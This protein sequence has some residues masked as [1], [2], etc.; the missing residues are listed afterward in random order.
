MSEPQTPQTAHGD[1]VSPHDG[2]S[3]TTSSTPAP[4]ISTTTTL[5]LPSFW[6]KNPKTWFRQVEALFQ[7]RRI[8]NQMTKY[9]EVL[10]LILPVLIDDIDDVLSS[11]R[12]DNAYD[13]LKSAIVSRTTVS[14]RARIQQLLTTN[15]LGDRRPS[16]LLHRMRQLLFDR[17][18]DHSA[19]LRELFLNRLPQDVRLILGGSD[20]V[21]FERLADLADRIT[22]YASAGVATVRSPTAAPPPATSELEGTIARLAGEMEKMLTQLADLQASLHGQ[23]RRPRSNSRRRPRASSQQRTQSPQYCWYHRRF[24][25]RSTRCQAPCSWQENSTAGQ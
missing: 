8:Q 1:G 19:I 11:I 4:T 17:S 7:A 18:D 2:G 5:R 23:T 13:T 12:P 20:D 15:G 10:P 25:H 16:Q 22:D 6:I 9:C 21:A 14:E 24:K 3:G